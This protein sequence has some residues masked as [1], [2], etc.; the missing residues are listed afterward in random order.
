M[1]QHLRANPSEKR[2]T[3]LYVVICVALILAVLQVYLLPFL[4]L[5]IW[6][7]LFTTPLVLLSGDRRKIP[8]FG[9]PITAV[10]AVQL[11]SAAWSPDPLQAVRS[12]ATTFALLVVLIATVELLTRKD[13]LVRRAL[14]ISGVAVVIHA[15]LIAVF[16]LVPTIE[17]QYLKSSVAPYL[18]GKGVTRIY[19]D[20]FNNVV[21]E[22]KAGGLFVNGNT[23]SMFMG[24]C[25]TVFL[26]S[27]VKFRSKWHVCV[28][29]FAYS[30][31][32]MTGSKT[33][34]FIGVV[35]IAACILLYT[36]ARRAHLVV[37]GVV[38]GILGVQIGLSA[39]LENSPEL[40]QDSTHTFGSRQ[41]M[42]NVAFKGLAES[43]V[44]GL[45]YGGWFEQYARFGSE[46]GF[47]VRPAHNLLLQTWLDSGVLG[48]FVVLFFYGSILVAC[49][50]ALRLNSGSG[51]V[52][53][54]VL[55]ASGW[56]FIHGQGDNTAFYGDTHS[57]AFLAVGLALVAHLPSSERG[58]SP[59][60]PTEVPHKA[61]R[62]RGNR[63]R[64]RA[65][66]NELAGPAPE[67]N[68]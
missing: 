2:A 18:S 64:D 31:A 63:S 16:F 13:T 68:E 59:E 23:A 27:G 48:T 17:A 53:C 19:G 30:G 3:L 55:A 11:I 57:L 44:L 8:V 36:A 1:T 67:H 5:A 15:L 41:L 49:L 61:V 52:A 40:A 62:L 20:L 46:I 56:V 42:W 26:A 58:L 47:S 32:L 66:R 12:A 39:L 54:S 9:L 51:I 37:P 14:S 10:G 7:I 35:W 21:L 38:A 24:V 65:A 22:G 4:P 33:A 45:G 34:L 43:P 6:W 28:A 25:A 50:K 29:S 60:R